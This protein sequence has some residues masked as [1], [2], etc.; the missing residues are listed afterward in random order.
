[1]GLFGSKN[2]HLAPVSDLEQRILKLEAIDTN[3]DGVI[4][5]QEFEQWKNTELAELKSAIRQEFQL[6]NK[7]LTNELDSIRQINRDLEAK[8]QAKNELIEKL[9]TH[10]EDDTNVDELLKA[11]SKEKIEKYIDD[12]LADENM[13]IQY[14]PDV[15]EKAVYRN[16]FRLMFKLMNTLLGTVNFELINHRLRIQMIPNATTN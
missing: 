10:F 12:I 3:K 4:S 7:N 2:N 5:R 1:M 8:L 15:I 11:L 14:F 9:G 13:N 6:E 16:V